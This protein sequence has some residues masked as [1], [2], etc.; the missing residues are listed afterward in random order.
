MPEII[1]LAMPK[2]SRHIALKINYLANQTA[3][4]GVQS[5][6]FQRGSVR[7]RTVWTGAPGLDFET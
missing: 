2:E 5:D 6:R 4:N 7:F 3:E 1:A